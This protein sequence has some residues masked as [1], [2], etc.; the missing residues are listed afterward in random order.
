MGLVLGMSILSISER[1]PDQPI[2]VF[3]SI[4]LGLVA[5]TLL[6]DMIALAAILCRLSSYG[7]T[8]NR[9]AVLGANLIVFCHL[10]G[11]LYHYACFIKK[12]GKLITVETWIVRFLPLYSLWSL[13][14]IIILPLLFGFA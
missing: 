5:I 3:D 13:T 4:N 9:I 7:F 12:R 1:K 8:P 11:I 6:V 14:V 2:N 10:A